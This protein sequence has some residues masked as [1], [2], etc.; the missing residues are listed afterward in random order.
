MDEDF[1][2][3][4][5]SRKH[6]KRKRQLQEQQD[7]LMLSLEERYIRKQQKK[8]LKQNMKSGNEPQEQPL[9][10]APPSENAQKDVGQQLD[11]KRKKK[12]K[13]KKD[14]KPV[15]VLKMG[16]QAIDLLAGDG[17]IVSKGSAIIA[18]YVGRLTHQNGKVFDQGTINFR[19]GRGEVIKGF[20]IG[21]LGMR[22]GSKRRLIIPPK[23]GYGKFKQGRIP[24]N[25]TLCFEISI[26]NISK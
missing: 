21:V 13:K 23:A 9:E 12:K 17:Q 18:K 20:D 22:L 14:S 6:R 10:K 8:K 15:R 16:I 24:A 2:H 4:R 5:V 25:S 19:V 11:Q 1:S 3:Y 26:I 7:E